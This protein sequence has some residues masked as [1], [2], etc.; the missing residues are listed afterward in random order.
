MDANLLPDD[1]DVGTL[2][3]QHHAETEQGIRVE[4]VAKAVTEEA[5]AL[6]TEDAATEIP[7]A[8][9]MTMSLM[10]LSADAVPLDEEILD[11]AIIEEADSESP[12]ETIMDTVDTEPEH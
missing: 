10:S 6:E 11:D 4:T 1:V 12:V 9:P 7:A 2:K 5:A 8:E 3:V